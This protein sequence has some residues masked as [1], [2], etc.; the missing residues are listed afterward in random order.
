MIDNVVSEELV[1]Q[2]WMSYSPD[3]DEPVL[4]AG[5]MTE[6]EKELAEQWLQIALPKRKRRK[7]KIPEGQLTLFEL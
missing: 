1:Q 3:D 4:P 5:Q 7:L 2:Q 6:K